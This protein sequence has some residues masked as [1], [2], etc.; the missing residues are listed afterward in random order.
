MKRPRNKTDINTDQEVP[1]INPNLQTKAAQYLVHQG[2]AKAGGVGEGSKKQVQRIER[3]LQDR[4]IAYK[5]DKS[6]SQESCTC[7]GPLK[8]LQTALKS[9]KNPKKR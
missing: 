3:D 9:P 4:K 7:R 8:T 6:T 1:R 2:Q 5:R